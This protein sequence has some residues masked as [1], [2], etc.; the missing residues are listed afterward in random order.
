MHNR[1][2]SQHRHV[3]NK[4]VLTVLPSLLFL[5]F[6]LLS[7]Q[8]SAAQGPGGSPKNP[9]MDPNLA[10]LEPLDGQH[11]LGAWLNMTGGTDTP[12]A[13]NKRLGRNASVFHFAQSIP[14]PP[15]VFPPFELLDQTAT[16][17]ILYL[18]VLPNK[19]LGEIRGKDLAILVD[20]C[21]R[22]NELGRRVF[23]RFAPGEDQMQLAPVSFSSIKSLIWI[24]WSLGFNGAWVPWG[25]QPI[26]FVT[27][28]RSLYSQLRAAKTANQTALV[29]SPFEGRGYPFSNEPFSV[30]PD[31]ENFKRL[32][33]DSD[34]NLT[35]KDEPYAPYWP[36][37]QYVDWVG[38]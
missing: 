24:S 32:D 14:E 30:K 18:S 3:N 11:Y 21:K 9:D 13:F 23:L 16:D 34:K 22:F 2:M 5:T 31:T 28:W 35:A 12:V 26:E 20:R 25:Q 29:W 37:D 15:G 17:A 7:P 38:L 4:N 10:I 6:L 19:G 8:P 27:L 36:G 33:T 1:N